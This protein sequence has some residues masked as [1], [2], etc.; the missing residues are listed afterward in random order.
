MEGNIGA[1]AD[2]IPTEE[3]TRRLLPLLLEHAAGAMLKLL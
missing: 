2:R 3:M 1:H